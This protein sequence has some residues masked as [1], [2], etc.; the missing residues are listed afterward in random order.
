MK[1]ITCILAIPVL[2][3]VLAVTPCSARDFMVEFIAENYKE[4]QIPFANT[5]RIYH[6]IQVNTHAGPKLLILTGEDLTYRTWLRQY[7]ADNKRFIVRVADPENDL[8]VASR[9]YEID[10][11]QLHPVS[12]DNRDSF[13]T[14]DAA[15]KQVGH[16]IGTGHIL[17]IDTNDTRSRLIADVITKMGYTPVI[18]TNGQQALEMF[19]VQPEKF[20]MVIAN[21]KAPGIETEA[22][23]EQVL[24][25]DHQIPILVET[26]YRDPETRQRYQ[27]RFSGAGSVVLTPMAL[28]DLQKNIQGMVK[29]VSTQENAPKENASMDEQQAA[30]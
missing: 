22:F 7:I 4:T 3:I 9:A 18:S 28:K 8:F 29:K 27:N 10:I 17:V 25:I 5:P 1:Q 6:S 23:V 26:G 14:K 2:I 24:N 19:R 15:A 16:I 30:S 11:T 21:H 12:S 13:F 20:Q